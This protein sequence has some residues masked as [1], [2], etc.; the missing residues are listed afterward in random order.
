MREEKGF[1]PGSQVRVGQGCSCPSCTISPCT[2]PPSAPAPLCPQP[3]L[4]SAL[5]LCSST[6]RP[7]LL[8]T[9]TPCS[10]LPSPRA[11]LCPHPVLLS[12]FSPCSSLPSA[13]APPPSARAP[14]HP[15]PVLLHPSPPA[16]LHPQPML[17]H[18]SPHASLH[19]QP[20]LL[21]ALSPCSSTLSSCSSTLHSMLFSALSLCSSA[22]HSM[23]LSA[24][25]PCSSLPSPHAPLCPHPVLP[26]TL[27]PCSSPPSARAPLRPQPVLLSAL[28]PCSPPPSAHVPVRPHPV[29]LHPSPRAPLHP[30]PVLR[31]AVLRLR[32]LCACPRLL[33]VCVHCAQQ[34]QRLRAAQSSVSSRA[35]A[36]RVQ[37][38][39]PE[40]FAR[41]QRCGDGRLP[42]QGP[43]V[44]LP[45]AAL[46]WCHLPPHPRQC[47]PSCVR[48]PEQ[49]RSSL[50]AVLS[51]QKSLRSLH[52]LRM[53]LSGR[54]WL[55]NSA[56]GPSGCWCPS[57]R[58]QCLQWHGHCPV[59][60]S[61]WSPGLYDR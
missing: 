34:T 39:L 20:M 1:A 7:V 55:W 51:T 8:S 29:L 31:S 41:V 23:L 21:Y 49:A 60:D 16:P 52:L 37:Q 58:E 36:I 17:L 4:L 50:V 32:H 15:K 48:F 24:L 18:P 2:S 59:E 53:L 22:P 12:A 14:L 38:S 10:S 47:L 26:S 40:R 9:L 30:H 56:L 28:P 25:T 13:H 6:P 27:S 5:S 45:P 57:L 3:V 61:R 42:S 54:L 33:A 35:P 11:P 43:G 44:C 19:P 46:R